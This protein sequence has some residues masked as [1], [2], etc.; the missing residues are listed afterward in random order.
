MGDIEDDDEQSQEKDQDD[1]GW[2]EAEDHSVNEELM[3]RLRC[4]SCITWCILY[5]EVKWCDV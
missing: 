5:N 2:V 3:K 4:K 1:D